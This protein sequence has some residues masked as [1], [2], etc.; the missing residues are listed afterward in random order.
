LLGDLFLQYAPRSTTPQDVGVRGGS[1]VRV[2][3]AREVE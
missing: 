1:A 2:T 3:Y